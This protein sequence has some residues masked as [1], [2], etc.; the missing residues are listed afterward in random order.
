M[1]FYKSGCRMTQRMAG[2]TLGTGT[3]ASPAVVSNVIPFSRRRGLLENTMVRNK[4]C[5]P[6]AGRPYLLFMETTGDMLSGSI[7]QNRVDGL[8]QKLVTGL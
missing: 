3:Q 5:S 6:D 8:R 2:E 1:G 4:E 7:R